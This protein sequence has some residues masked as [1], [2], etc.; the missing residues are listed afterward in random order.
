MAQF[1]HLMAG[2]KLAGRMPSAASLVAKDMMGT[3]LAVSP[4]QAVFRTSQ[5]VAYLSIAHTTSPVCLKCSC[6]GS[7]G[8]RFRDRLSGSMYGLAELAV[9]SCIRSTH[10]AELYQVV[11]EV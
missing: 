8:R 7:S 1:E 6:A 11:T 4:S 10:S 5:S 3:L 2:R 9:R